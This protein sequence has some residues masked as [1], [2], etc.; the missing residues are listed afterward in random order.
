MTDRERVTF[1]CR[2]RLR[3]ECKAA[4]GNPRTSS[5]DRSGGRCDRGGLSFAADRGDKEGEAHPGQ[6]E[7]GRLGDDLRGRPSP[8][9]LALIL[10]L[11]LVLNLGLGLRLGLGL[12]L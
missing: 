5:R 8:V 9:I 7:R 4:S 11:I 6:D 12:A 3:M 10:A 2:L 1:F